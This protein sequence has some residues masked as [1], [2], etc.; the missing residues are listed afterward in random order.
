MLLELFL[1][2]PD[3]YAT[4]TSTCYIDEVEGESPSDVDYIFAWGYGW[5]KRLIESDSND[6]AATILSQEDHVEEGGITRSLQPS[7]KS[8]SES[9]AASVGPTSYNSIHVEP[10]GCHFKSKWLHHYYALLWTILLLPVS[11]SRVHL[12]DHSPMQI[13]VGSFVGIA[14]GF[15]WYFCIIRG[16]LFRSSTANSKGIMVYLVNCRLG[17]WIGLNFGVGRGRIRVHC[18]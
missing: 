9:E 17:K 1:Y 12:H 18:N 10:Q 11:L 2:H 15:I 6:L 16:W 8:T 13:L 7:S 5:Q 14:L 4:T 3:L